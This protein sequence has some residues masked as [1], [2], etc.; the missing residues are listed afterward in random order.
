MNA[1]LKTSGNKRH[2]EGSVF[3]TGRQTLVMFHNSDDNMLS[4]RA[5][6]KFRLPVNG[7]SKHSRAVVEVQEILGATPTISGIHVQA[8]SLKR[9]SS[10]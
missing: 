1:G 3:F 8:R 7:H 2:S 10:R 4:R 6:F 9:V 5:C